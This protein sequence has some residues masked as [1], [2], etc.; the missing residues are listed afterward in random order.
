MKIVVENGSDHA[1][2]DASLVRI[3][4]RSH[5]IRDRLFQDK[6]LTLEEIAKSEE[7][8]PSYATRLLR[9]TVLRPTSSARS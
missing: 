3:V 2:P 6:S 5:A 8:T 9:L 1:I 4:I 7:M